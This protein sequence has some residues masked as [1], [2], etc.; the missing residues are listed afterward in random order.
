MNDLI[1][2]GYWGLGN[3][4]K[5]AEYTQRN[6]LFMQRLSYSE[7]LGAIFT[8]TVDQYMYADR[9]PVREWIKQFRKM[10]E[11]ANDQL[12]VAHTYLQEGNKLLGDSGD[13]RGVITAKQHALEFYLKTGSKFSTRQCLHS[14]ADTYYE[15]G[16]FAKA[17]EQFDKVMQVEGFEED[18]WVKVF[19]FEHMGEFLLAEGRFEEAVVAFRQFLESLETSQFRRCVCHR[20][21]TFRLLVVL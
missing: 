4:A 20:R 2:F 1:A 5:S 8:F 12:R 13:L 21:K 18:T 16:D 9:R 11:E 19:Y 15:L 7:D 6:A 10:A 14:L 3:R 17:K